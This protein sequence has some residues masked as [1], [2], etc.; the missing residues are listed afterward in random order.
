MQL[1]LYS[2]PHT[3][4]LI[5]RNFS[6]NP[7]TVILSAG[8]DH[9]Q[10]HTT[11]GRWSFPHMFTV[12]YSVINK[13]V[14]TQQSLSPTLPPSNSSCELVLRHG[15][16][17]CPRNKKP[18]P[19]TLMLLLKIMANQEDNPSQLPYNT[20]FSNMFQKKKKCFLRRT[21]PPH[22]MLHLRPDVTEVLQQ[23]EQVAK[24][25]LLCQQV[26]GDLGSVRD[27]QARRRKRAIMLLGWAAGTHGHKHQLRT[28]PTKLVKSQ[29]TAV[30]SSKQSNGLP[31]KHQL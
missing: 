18:F 13:P 5:K 9:S 22:Q 21:Q 20:D 24:V 19:T 28:K 27:W 8:Q 3:G 1:S 14:N 30:V 10:L 16:L 29:C 11:A 31:H 6:S 7:F 26:L 17:L 15:K 25:R 23:R 2:N 4:Y 12:P